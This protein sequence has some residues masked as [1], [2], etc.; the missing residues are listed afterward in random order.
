MAL[1]AINRPVSGTKPP[2]PVSINWG[3]PCARGLALCLLF[4]EGGGAPVDLVRQRRPALNGTPAWNSGLMFDGPCLDFDGTG[5]YL[6]FGDEPEFSPTFGPGF[7]CFTRFRKDAATTNRHWLV[8]KGTGS[9]YEF[10][11]YLGDGVDIGADEDIV[12]VIWDASGN[13]GGLRAT[14]TLTS[15]GV[16]TTAAF[17]WAGGLAT[18]DVFFNGQPD[19]G[20]S[21]NSLTGPAGT[22]SLLLVGE[23]QDLGG[24]EFN[25]AMDILMLWNRQLLAPEIAELH[26]N[27]YCFL[28]PR[29]RTF[30]LNSAAAAAALGPP[31]LH[32]SVNMRRQQATIGR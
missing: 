9:N 27:P 21:S 19:N 7:S 23:R 4:N 2:L 16:W 3:H 29:R 31:Q 15:V 17:T 13:T 8:S 32:P 20:A 25:G 26:R 28:M 10:G 12:A 18:P 11:F 1:I 14:A 30:W 6:D 24:A 22:A 5:D